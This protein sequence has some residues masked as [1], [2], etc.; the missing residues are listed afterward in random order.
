[1]PDE[2][3]PFLNPD[4]TPS[5]NTLKVLCILTF[6]GSGFN[7]FLTAFISFFYSVFRAVT[8]ESLKEV[9]LSADQIKLAEEGIFLINFILYLASVR[10]AFLMWNMKKTGFH[11][12]S[13]AQILI[14]ITPLIFFKGLP[15][16]GINILITFLFIISYAR[17]IRIM[18]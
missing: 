8:P 9:H 12:Y 3:S 16:A 4:Y 6:I 13:I 15:T 2:K 11:L 18:Q 7:A 10:G 5:T 1:M 17:F 14:L